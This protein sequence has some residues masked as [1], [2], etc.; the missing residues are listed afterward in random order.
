MQAPSA[1]ARGGV[2]IGGVSFGAR[3]YT[4]ALPEPQEQAIQRSDGAYTLV[5]PPASAALVTF[6]L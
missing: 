4:G 5:V 6:Q 1:W 3:T 2:T